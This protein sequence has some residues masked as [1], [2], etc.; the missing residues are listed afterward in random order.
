MSAMPPQ[1]YASPPGYA[2]PAAEQQSDGQGGRGKGKSGGKR[3]KGKKSAKQPGASGSRIRLIA[4]LLFALIA[5]VVVVVSLGE[6]GPTTAYVVHA[7][8]AIA[9]QSELSA[10]M[11]VGQETIVDEA[12]TRAVENGDIFASS[13]PDEAVRAA[14]DEL[15]GFRTQYPIRQGERVHVADFATEVGTVDEPLGPDERLVSVEVS[16]AR[17][18]AGRLRAGDRVD[19]LGLIDGIVGVVATDVPIVQVTLS[20][21]RFESAASRAADEGVPRDEA[22]PSDPVPGMYLLR[23]PAAQAQ[24]IV[25]VDQGAQ[26]VFI[27]RPIGANVLTPKALTALDVVCGSGFTLEDGTPIAPSELPEKCEGMQDTAPPPSAPPPQAPGAP[28]G[29]EPP[30]EPDDATFDEGMDGPLEP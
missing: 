22:L 18:V 11:L 29:L 10:G 25:A 26:M 28:D 1:G 9:A 14:L 4:A 6:D 15:E 23:L 19:I 5:I 30:P 12:L 16:V 2:Q 8:Q 7:E 24:R 27:Y 13:D 3:R 17:S 21:S 20:E